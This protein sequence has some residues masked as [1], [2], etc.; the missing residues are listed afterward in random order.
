METMQVYREQQCSPLDA[1]YLAGPS[2]CSGYHVACK[3]SP[4]GLAPCRVAE[5][6]RPFSVA[7]QAPAAELAPKAR[8]EFVLDVARIISNFY[9]LSS[10]AQ[11]R[12]G[13]RD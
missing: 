7:V 6:K 1:L 13:E 3:S 5:A 2:I 9:D 11:G 10:I 8:P 12:A 4:A